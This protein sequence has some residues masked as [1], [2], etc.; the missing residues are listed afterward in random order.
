MDI[1]RWLLNST[2]WIAHEFQKVEI[3]AANQRM[4]VRQ[5]STLIISPWGGQN[6]HLN[7]RPRLRVLRVS[8]FSAGGQLS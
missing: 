1:P 2:D 5:G 7:S 4:V 6:V 3:Q 8:A